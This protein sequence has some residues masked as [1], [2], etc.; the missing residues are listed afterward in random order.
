MSEAGGHGEVTR[1]THT[2][3]EKAAQWF[4]SHYP[5]LGGLAAGFKIIEDYSYCNQEEISVAA[6]NVTAGRFMSIRQQD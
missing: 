5:L 6:V 2:A 4:I 1:N 3:S